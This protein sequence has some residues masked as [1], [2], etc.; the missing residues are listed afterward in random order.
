MRLRCVLRQVWFIVFLA[1]CAVP[2]AAEDRE[3]QTSSPSGQELPPVR[4]EPQ[5]LRPGDHGVGRYVEDE[6]FKDVLGG[7]H[8]LSDWKDRKAAIVAM[9]STSCPLSKKYLP[10]LTDLAES[11][12]KRDVAVLLV[13]PVATDKLEEMQSIAES[14]AGTAVYV[15]DA[16]GQL[17]NAV[18]AK[19]TTDAIL[20]DGSRTVIYHGAVD[21]QYGFGY[22]KQAPRQTYLVSAVESFL[23]GRSLLVKATAAPGCAIQSDQK[24]ET[25]GVTYHNRI[26]R[27]MNQH[28]VECHRDGGVAPFE[29]TSYDDVVAHGPM[30]KFVIQRG[31]MPP[32]FAAP[33]PGHTASQWSNDR[34]LS[35]SE[36][37][38]LMAWLD[39]G[40]PLGNQ[41]D[42]APMREFADGWLIGK[43]DA[44]FEMPR[45]ITIK[46]SG[47]MPYQYVTTETD[48]DEDKWVQAIEVQPGN[49]EV[50]HHVLVFDE[51]PGQEDRFRGGVNGFF[52]AYVPGNGT[53]IYPD[54]IA[55]R[56]PKGARLKFQLHYTPIGRA[57]EDQTRIGLIF[58][59]QPPKHEVHVAGLANTNLNIPPQAENFAD[60]AQRKL[61]V[62]IQVLSL[63]PHMHLRG[64]ACRYEL[65]DPQGHSTLLLDVPRYD[66]NWQLP[67]RYTQPRLI[68][69]GST[70]K[71]T[72]WFDNS[73]G[74]PANPD[75][76]Q[77][78][79]WGEQTFEEM[80]L[81]YVEYIVPGQQP[82]SSPGP[83]AAK[84][85]G[86]RRLTVEQ[87][88]QRFDRNKD[89]R[90][91][92]QELPRPALFQQLDSNR[93]GFITKDELRSR[94]RGG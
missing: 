10:T 36:T 44:I 2:A 46:A 30:I 49:R 89:G 50:V 79:H 29:L 38:D 33:D 5:V 68:P 73:S 31:V 75:P 20:L 84:P 54:G 92:K 26:S 4:E 88:I 40:T 15:H 32:W 6:Q 7:V 69:K 17:A 47:V 1:I 35:E 28:C 11:F 48:F 85:S 87:T 9:T 12:A 16:T 55:R 76:S 8:R 45:P 71:F 61:P 25:V 94:G 62:D 52:G 37:S 59:K 24:T 41:R 53:L 21:D 43:P 27:L 91:S 58:A 39:G 81:G 86:N 93:D 90:L 56:L 83:L 23:A 74:N 14:V 60:S 64:K 66:F 72:A 51:L 57:T 82:G 34:T 22:S 80:L 67:Y 65:L 19:T 77:T 42:A 3:T 70:I 13:N 18:G 63:L 78:V